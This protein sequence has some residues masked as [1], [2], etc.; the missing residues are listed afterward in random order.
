MQ[1]FPESGHK[2]LPQEAMLTLFGS[3]AA[4]IMMLA[5][6]LEPRSK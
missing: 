2:A 4:A 5:Y 1:R 3:V 6:W